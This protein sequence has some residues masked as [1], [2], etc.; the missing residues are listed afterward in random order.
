LHNT[1][2]TILTIDERGRIRFSNKPLWGYSVSALY[3]TQILDLLP[4]E[5]HPNVMQCITQTFRHFK[6]S[7]CDVTGVEP[8]G[9]RRFNL[10]FGTPQPDQADAKTTIATMV[11]REI[12]DH[13]RTEEDLRQ[14]GE[15]LRYFAAHVEAA[16]EEERTRVAREIHDELGQKLTALKLDLAWVERKTR[17]NSNLKKKMQE[18]ITDVD[19][20]IDHVRQISSDLR[21]AMLDDLG[22]I[23]AIEWQL[24]QFRRRTR[25]RTEFIHGKG[26]PEFSPEAAAAVFRVVQEALTNIMRHAGA[27]RVVIS[28]SRTRDGVRFTII[29]NGRGMTKGEESG[30]KSLGIVGMK[31]RISRLG[32]H[33]KLFSEPGKGTRLDFAIPVKDDQSLRS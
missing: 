25:V 14:S 19:A 22:L 9:A 4:K 23:P 28:L 33:L 2:D 6:R 15:Q 11:I 29:D 31:E 13:K 3:G 16:R 12:S 17:R 7:M 26:I 10:S 5:E 32:G 18:M 20:T 8:F 21:P 27:T 1:P 24:L 30:L